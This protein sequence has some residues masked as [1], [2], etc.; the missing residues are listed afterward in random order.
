MKRFVSTVMC[1]CLILTALPVLAADI[2]DVMR[3]TNCKEWVS[4]RER[5]D[6]A[7]KRL[8]KV[9]LDELVTGC[10]A[11]SGDFI[12]CEYNG[13]VGYIQSKYL[14]RA[15]SSAPVQ[16]T[17]QPA[18]DTG[19]NGISMIVVNCANWVSLRE[20]ASASSARLAKVP[21]GTRV[22][23][24]VQVSESFVYCS[25]NGVYGYI[26]TQ[27]LSEPESNEPPETETEPEA[28]PETAAN[29]AAEP[30]GFIALPVLPDY[31]S[32]TQT[33]S[34]VMAETYQGYTIVV[35]RV[36]GDYEE[37]LA[38]CYDLNNKPQW[39]LYAQSLE[40]ASDVQQLD[41]FVAG[42]IEDPQLI[43]YIHGLGFYSYEYGPT[44]QLRWFLPD[45]EGLE[46]TGSII[47]TEDYDGHI[48]VA[49]GDVLIRISPEGELLWRT[50][51]EDPSLFWPISIEID[52][53]GISVFY[54]N[55]FGVNNMY[56]Q[57]RFDFD[58]VLQSTTQR[59][60]N[61]QA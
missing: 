52:E 17:V 47:H 44:L 13:K 9:N 43:W 38:V 26:Q 61:E 48:Y 45:S 34:T 22:D 46:I 40:T 31:E 24:C 32:L 53:D 27:Y 29:P 3:V 58:G 8:E 54:N 6:A 55:L 18:D 39:R 56:T 14:T 25:Y 60:I 12:R 10:T 21:L 33:G 4:L 41:A 28:D 7:S 20:K 35:Q 36:S 19:I 51:C 1:L 59:T 11:A 5:P 23:N 57:A 2:S 16:P 37:M 50:S 15:D 42:T 49:F 30:S